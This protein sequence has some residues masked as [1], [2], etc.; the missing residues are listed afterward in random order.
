MH[1]QQNV[2]FKNLWTRLINIQELRYTT[3]LIFWKLLYVWQSVYNDVWSSQI[4]TECY[5]VQDCDLGQQSVLH[6]VQS[7]H[8]SSKSRLESPSEGA[9]P[10]NETLID[11]QLNDQERRNLKTDE[12]YYYL[13]GHSFF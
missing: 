2:K 12:G 9:R 5:A 13:W 6:A 11:L 3:S 10:L 1:G 8:S 7:R 4:L